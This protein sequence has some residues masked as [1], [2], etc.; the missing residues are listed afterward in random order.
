[1][2]TLQERYE[3][4]D[5]KSSESRFDSLETSAKDLA[6][7]FEDYPELASLYKKADALLMAVQKQKKK[8]IST[9]DG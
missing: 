7:G 8:I 3:Q 4:L 1:M 5:E 6:Y 2:K 9:M